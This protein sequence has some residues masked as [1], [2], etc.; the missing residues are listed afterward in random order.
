MLSGKPI[1]FI[2]LWQSFPMKQ[3]LTSLAFF[4]IATIPVS[5]FAQNVTTKNSLIQKPIGKFDPISGLEINALELSTDAVLKTKT[6]STL[7]LKS[8]LPVA[9]KKE[10]ITETRFSY[11]MPI[12][13]PKKS[14]KILLAN[15]DQNSPYKYN[16]PIKR[17]EIEEA[18]KT[19]E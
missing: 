13:K 12:Y 15:L 18:Q 2:H 5:L 6:D 10:V 14:S 8:R 9:G 4:V 16:M 3:L 19:A 17:L 11:N 7:I 1:F